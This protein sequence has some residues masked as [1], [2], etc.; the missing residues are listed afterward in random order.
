MTKLDG[1]YKVTKIKVNDE[2]A[3]RMVQPGF[4]VTGEVEVEVGAPM[5]V[6][7]ETFFETLRTSLVEKIEPAN[8]GNY[9]VATRNSVYS[10]EKINE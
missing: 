5:F 1:I 7:G 9:L 3:Y 6:T 8:N 4:E 10:L 2:T